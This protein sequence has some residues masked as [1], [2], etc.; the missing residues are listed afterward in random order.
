MSTSVG[1]FEK[2]GYMYPTNLRRLSYFTP[3]PKQNLKGSIERTFVKDA[4]SLACSVA[5]RQALSAQC[6]SK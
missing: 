1:Y 2:Y 6:C 4:S 5:Q 3:Y